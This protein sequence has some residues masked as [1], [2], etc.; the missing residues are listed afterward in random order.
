[1]HVQAQKRAGPIPA[2]RFQEFEGGSM[3]DVL[4]D[5]EGL[6]LENGETMPQANGDVHHLPEVPDEVKLDDP[7]DANPSTAEHAGESRYPLPRR[8]HTGM[9]MSSQICFAVMRVAFS[10][11]ACIH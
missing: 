11:R 7:I 10:V 3:R 1:M 2:K 9:S 8:P 4:A 5:L 6:S